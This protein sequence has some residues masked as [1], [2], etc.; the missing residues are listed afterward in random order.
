MSAARVVVT[1]NLVLDEQFRLLRADVVNGDGGW[2]YKDV[3]KYLLRR[4]S[5]LR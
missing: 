4:Q 2:S 3:A 1:G 5:L